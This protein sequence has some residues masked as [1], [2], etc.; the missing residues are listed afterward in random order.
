MAQVPPG[1]RLD[2]P[3]RRAL[4]PRALAAARSAGLDLADPVLAQAFAEGLDFAGELLA[5]DGAAGAVDSA[6]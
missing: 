1:S 6:A 3:L 2:A 5:K 4:P